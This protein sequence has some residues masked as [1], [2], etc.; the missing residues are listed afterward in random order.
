MWQPLCETVGELGGGNGSWVAGHHLCQLIRWRAQK[1]PLPR[2]HLPFLPNLISYQPSSLK[3]SMLYGHGAILPFHI[4]SFR[5]LV[6]SFGKDTCR[7]MG[8]DKR[9]SQFECSNPLR[10]RL[11]AAFIGAGV[12]PLICHPLASHQIFS[13]ICVAISPCTKYSTKHFP[14]SLAAPN[15]CRRGEKVGREAL[16]HLHHSVTSCTLLA[17]CLHTACTLLFLTAFLS[18]ALHTTIQT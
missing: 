11:Q 1:K 9:S 2:S 4:E 17:H 6:D 13:R 10:E 14:C 18:I 8:Q 15:I 5:C 16:A 12:A 7:Q 3:L